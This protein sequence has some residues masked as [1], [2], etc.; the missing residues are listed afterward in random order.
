MRRSRAS[1]S[2]ASN[3]ARAAA[4]NSLAISC[5][6]LV[7][8]SLVIFFCALLIALILAA[9]GYVPSQFQARTA[10]DLAIVQS[11]L[12]HVA[13][14][15]LFSGAQLV[16]SLLLA[17]SVVHAYARSLAL[18]PLRLLVL[19]LLFP[20][21]LPSAILA[22]TWKPLLSSLGPIHSAA[23]HVFGVDLPLLSTRDMCGPYIDC[24]NYGTFSYFVVDS[25][26]W[27]LF[28][29][30]STL[31]Y[32]RVLYANQEQLAIVDNLNT[33]KFFFKLFI[34]LTAPWLIFVYFLNTSRVI[35][36]FDITFVFFG[37]NP[38]QRTA[39][40]QAFVSGINQFRLEEAAIV[41]LLTFVISAAM[42]TVG[43][44]IAQSYYTRK[45][46]TTS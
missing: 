16:L 43:F 14:S 13:S 28:L 1:S 17:F 6:G 8:A 39:S 2:P 33:A 23:R 34:P 24:A 42:Y 36:E 3:A 9:F 30:A 45:I 31:L 22:F 21:L 10:V 18:L 27:V 25:W 5:I 11:G 29:C 20:F 7:V 41:S 46:K 19:G 4:Y 15:V 44:L 37:T 38:I 26:A 12:N 35:S 32:F 40:V